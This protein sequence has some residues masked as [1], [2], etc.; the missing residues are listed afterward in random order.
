MVRLRRPTALAAVMRKEVRQTVRDK[1]VLAILLVAPVMQLV[2]LGYAVNLDVHDVPTVVADEDRTAESRAF[3]EGLV[4]GDTFRLDA[5]RDRASEAVARVTRGESAVAVIVPRGFAD[6]LG[7]GETAE[8][9]VLT[10]GSDSNRAIVAQNAASAYGLRRALAAAEATSARLAAA[11]GAA[12][13]L[14]RIAVEPRVLYNATL[15]SARYFVPGMAATLLLIVSVVVTA[16]GLA[17]EKESG[18][19]EQVLVTP[20]QPVTLIAGKTLPYGVIGLV[21]LGLVVTAAMVMFGVPL[22]GDLAVIFAGGALYLLSTLGV[23]LFVSTVARNQQQAFMTSVLVILPAILLSGFMTPIGNMPEW[24]QPVTAL[25]PVRHMVE[26]LRAVMLKGAGF[27]DVAPQL[28]AL[29][30]IGLSVFGMAAMVMARRL[31]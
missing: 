3:I 11:R 10:D 17:R 4:A 22:R 5:W 26:I 8:V 14:P 23:G 28:V 21:D 19:L 1:R 16:M 2:V 6:A 27:A 30:G 25:N 13:S 18:T 7:R 15:D 29:A 31:R 9:Q 12:V 20:I 24:L